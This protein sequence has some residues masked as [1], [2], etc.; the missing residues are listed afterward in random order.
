MQEAHAIEMA[1]KQQQLQMQQM[2]AQQQMA[3]GGQVHAQKLSH[4]DQM[5]QIKLNQGNGESN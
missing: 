2:Q 1:G 5:A 4:A 3:Q